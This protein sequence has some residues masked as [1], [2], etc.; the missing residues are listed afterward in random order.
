VSDKTLVIATWGQPALWCTACYMLE[1]EH[2]GVEHCT[3]LPL[4]LK[5][6]NNSDVAL[7]VLDSLINEFKRKPTCIA[8]SKCF[9][10]YDKLREFV[11]SAASSSSYKELKEKLKE[12]VHEMLECL[13]INGQIEPIVCP[14]VG[15]PSGQWEFNN[16]PRD[17][18]AVALAELGL[19]FL[20][21]G[22]IA[23]SSTSATASTSCPL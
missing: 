11:R 6:Y 10:C 2:E 3:T 17:Y 21:N 23:W 16:S 22:T 7:L 19:R 4:L 8:G 20:V 14:A 15:K 9:E 5:H 18:E 12:F 1:D 13:E